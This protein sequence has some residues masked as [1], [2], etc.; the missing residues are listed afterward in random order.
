[1]FKRAGNAVQPAFI[2]QKKTLSLRF[3]MLVCNVISSIKSSWT[4]S[5]IN[6]LQQETDVSGTIS[7]PMMGTE[8]IS[9]CNQLAQL[10]AREDF[11]EFSRCESFKLYNVVSPKKLHLI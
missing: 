2:L 5:R 8:I 4:R 6:W 3:I 11:I 10:C 9:S 1:M 7:V